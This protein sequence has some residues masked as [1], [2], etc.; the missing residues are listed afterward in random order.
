M[1]RPHEE[2]LPATRSPKAPRSPLRDLANLH[3]ALAKEND[4]GLN[5][6]MWGSCGSP[7]CSLGYA[8]EYGIAGFGWRRSI[9]FDSVWP[10]REG[11]GWP[12]LSAVKAF[13]ITE[14]EAGDLFGQAARTHLQQAD[15]L[16]GIATKVEARM[17]ETTLA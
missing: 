17:M 12:F 5:Q 3:R 7:A 9:I 10:L 4:D 13:N 6:S 11:G 2:F 1:Y 15:L 16:E 14:T 8:A